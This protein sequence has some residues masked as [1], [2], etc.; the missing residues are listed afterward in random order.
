MKVSAPFTLANDFGE[1]AFCGAFESIWFMTCSSFHLPPRAFVAT[2][3]EGDGFG[4]LI[5][6]LQDYLN[7]IQVVRACL[8]GPAPCGG[9]IDKPFFDSPSGSSEGQV[10]GVAKVVSRTGRIRGSEGRD[11]A[12]FIEP[13]VHNRTPAHGKAMSVFGQL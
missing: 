10:R 5:S 3:D 9:G 2:E 8:L 1:P 12:P 11:Q 7:K 6:S 4:M 13:I